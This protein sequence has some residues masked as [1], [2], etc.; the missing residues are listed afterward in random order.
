ML[1]PLYVCM[2]LCVLCACVCYCTGMC[3]DLLTQPDSKGVSSYTIWTLLIN[4]LHIHTYNYCQVRQPG[5][6]STDTRSH[7]H[8]LK[9]FGVL[10]VWLAGRREPQ[11][12]VCVLYLS[13]SFI[14]LQVHQR[15]GV[16]SGAA[17]V[18]L[19]SL[20]GVDELAGEAVAVVHV[21]AAAAPQP[22]A[23]QVAG[24]SGAAA[25]AGG[26]LTFAARPADGVD[27]AGRADGV[28]EGGFSGA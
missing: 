1:L 2:G 25:A 5:A 12:R 7:A 27:H 16:L 11:V 24:A 9:T 6:A 26:E 20:P 8:S 21:V 28:G 22:V 18:V 17:G 13:P 3:V 4:N 19:L 23:R 14:V 15:P 10:T